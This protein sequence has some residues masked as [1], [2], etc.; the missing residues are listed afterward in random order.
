MT[1]CTTIKVI[2]TSALLFALGG[3]ALPKIPTKIQDPQVA[4]SPDSIAAR[5]AEAA[6]RSSRSLETL[7]A[8]EQADNP[9]AAIA[10]IP[11]APQELRRTIT[12]DWYGPVEQVTQEVAGR[13][14]YNFKVFGSSPPTP[15]IVTIRA[16]NRQVIDVLRDIGLQLGNLA[17][18]RVDAAT[19]AIEIHYASALEDPA[20]AF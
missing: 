4:V 15:V 13:A 6:D 9:N 8:V 14:S 11:N 2:A 20:K 17:N 7:A 19:R 18:L 12:V 3:C 5:L 16:Q 1:N 10:S